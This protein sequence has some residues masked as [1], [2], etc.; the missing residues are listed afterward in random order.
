MMIGMTPHAPWTAEPVRGR[1][2]LR[3]GAWWWTV[4]DVAGR[5]VTESLGASIPGERIERLHEPLRWEL[6]DGC[7]AAFGRDAEVTWHTPTQATIRLTPPQP[8]R[9]PDRPVPLVVDL[10]PDHG[11]RL[12]GADLPFDLPADE[13]R[14]RLARLGP[15]E[16]AWTCGF[17]HTF[18][19]R[20]GRQ[21][22]SVHCLDGVEGVLLA[23]HRPW[24]GPVEL[25][26]EYRDLNLLGD[27]IELVKELLAEL[28][29]ELPTEPGRPAP[30][31][32]RLQPDADGRVAEAWFVRTI[33]GRR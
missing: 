11:V 13:A 26:A 27:P 2:D 15:V 6:A 32:P 10:D 25:R 8:G 12:P 17:T 14:A 22:L 31:T 19:V 28:P 1:L 16:D 4:T 33:P 30:P 20:V 9:P 18:R 21:S 29:T 3:D 24:P 5:A 7:F 23:R